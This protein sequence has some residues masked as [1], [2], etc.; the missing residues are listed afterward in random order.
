MLSPVA[1]VKKLRTLKSPALKT[2]GMLPPGLTV[3]LEA[4]VFGSSLQIFPW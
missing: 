3:S 1:K 4:N 2:L